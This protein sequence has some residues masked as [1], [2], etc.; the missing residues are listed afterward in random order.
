MTCANSRAPLRSIVVVGGGPVALVAALAFARAAHVQVTLVATPDDPA[1]L[2]DRLPVA[3]PSTLAFLA[4]LGLGEAALID[5]GAT[6]RTGERY[7]WGQAAFVIGEGGGVQTVAG[8]ALHQL[9]LARGAKGRFDALVPA[10]AMAMADRFGRPEGEAGS[11]LSYVDHALR[12]DPAECRQV[13]AQRSRASGVVFRSTAALAVEREGEMVATVTL[14]DGTRLQADLF[15]DASGPAALLGGPGGE[16]IDWSSALPVDRLLIAHSPGR[17]A[18]ID[19]YEAT[20]IGWSATIP[21]RDRTIKLAGYAGSATADGRAMRQFGQSA[22]RIVL[23]PGRQVRP[24][25][26]N[27]LALGDAAAV[28][29]PLGL[30]GFALAC[31][32]LALA[33]DLLPARVPEPLLTAEYNRRATLRADE[34]RDHAAAFYAVTSPRGGEFW[35]PLRQRPAPEP[36]AALLVQF[37]QRGTLPPL[38]EEA[39][40]RSTWIQTLIGL[41]IRPVRTDPIALS[42]PAATADAAIERLRGAVAALPATLPRYA[43]CL[44]TLTKG[45]R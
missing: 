25:A 3:P 41:G 8:A 20:A 14:T 9:W 33:L 40:A 24:L 38:T 42:V 15:V 34:V 37:R 4:T 29:G 19:R 44:A 23:R 31:S 32:H 11:L 1:A 27:V 2:A 22:E 6:H 43:D 21:L 16:R 26:G 39:V 18:L 10:A 45:L 7:D 12:L 28:A 35:H 36:L 5:G 30:P 13:F 17:G